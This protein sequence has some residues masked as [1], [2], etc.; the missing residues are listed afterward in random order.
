[1]LT[2]AMAAGGCSATGTG[3]PTASETT[4]TSLPAASAKPRCRPAA[5]CTTRRLADAAG[6]TFG[7]AVSAAHLDEGRYRRTIIE[8]FNSVTP[9]NAMKWAS[10]HPEPNEWNF[11]P[12]DRIVRFAGAHHMQIKGHALLF[13]QVDGDSTPDWVL[14]ID[15]PDELR[16]A[17]A[18]HFTTLMR[19]YRG[20]VDR[21]DV[22]N[23]PLE[24][25]GTGQ[26]DSHFRAVLGDDYISQVFEI[27]HE[28]DPSAR[29]FLNEAAAE[30][31][32]AKAAALVA[33]VERLRRAGTP[34]HGVGLQAHLVGGTVDAAA[35]G[36]LIGRLE[37]L[38]VSVAITELD[39]PTGPG[40]EAAATQADTYAR[41]LRACF[42]TQCREVTTWG[43]TDRY[44][45]IDT[46]LRPGLAPL[47]FDADYRPKP[48]L[49][50]IRRELAA[51]ASG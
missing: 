41:V 23:E 36:N 5:R 48:A 26:Y 49:E 10:I 8:T 11:D 7:T 12:F 29:L 45:W 14:A 22:V 39:V 25:L 27:A 4:R 3:V 17:I 31:L 19:R 51:A 21:W 1:M 37:R 46:F 2:L 15:D 6:V 50:A 40:P 13:D 18:D 24:R 28:A 16:A 33:L 9:E 42:R 35:L 47:P 30:L 43:F 38:G 34:V 32:P 20:K 44:T